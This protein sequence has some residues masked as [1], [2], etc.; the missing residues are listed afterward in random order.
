[1]L[2]TFT[3]N[4]KKPTPLH[5]HVMNKIVNYLYTKKSFAQKYMH[6]VVSDHCI[7]FCAGQEN[8]TPANS[9]ENCSSTT[10]LV[11]QNNFNL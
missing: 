9:L 11:P 3:R 7:I 6:V 4:N 2:I 8:R 1:M 10:K 5:I